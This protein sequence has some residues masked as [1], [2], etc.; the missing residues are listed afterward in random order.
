MHDQDDSSIRLVVGLG[1]PG[2]RYART[3]HNIGFDVVDAA[4][5]RWSATGP[6]T[7]FGGL[8]YDARPVAPDGRTARVVLLQ[9]H[10]FMNDSGRAV[11]EIAAFYKA[12]I[13]DILIVLDD[14]DLPPGKLRIRAGGSA[15][16]HRGLNDIIRSMGD[17]GIGRLR[18]GIGAAPEFMESSDYVLQRFADDEVDT[19]RQAVERGAEAVEDW[20]FNGP[21]HAMDTYN[22]NAGEDSGVTNQQDPTRQDS[23]N[24]T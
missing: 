14:L 15:G 22:R 5:R 3:R 12:Q 20:I 13:A 10:T 17:Q 4:V 23:E 21:L 6:K 11:R 18:I 8:V 9:P 7:A 2:S 19:I 16:G 24:G 1:N